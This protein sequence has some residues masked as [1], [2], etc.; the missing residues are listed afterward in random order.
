MR[1]DSFLYGC[2]CIC[3]NPFWG[4]GLEHLKRWVTDEEIYHGIRPGNHKFPLYFI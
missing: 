1:N 2:F 4:T 3:K